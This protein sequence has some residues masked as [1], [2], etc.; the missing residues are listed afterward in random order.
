MGSEELKGEEMV[1]ETCKLT[2]SI[3][4]LRHH[5]R[6]RIGSQVVFGQVYGFGDGGDFRSIGFEHGQPFPRELRPPADRL[7]PHFA[8]VRR[9]GE[10]LYV[11]VIVHGEKDR[12]FDEI[13][14]S[15]DP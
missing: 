13:R 7:G 5:T 10:V 14:P 6:G 8:K 9:R 3:S 1:L 11:A 12:A 2:P 15:Y 4:I